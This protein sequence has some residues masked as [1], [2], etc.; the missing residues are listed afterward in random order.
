M[1]HRRI[2]IDLPTEIYEQC[3]L[4]AEIDGLTLSELVR[5]LLVE[6]F[7]VQRKAGGI[8]PDGFQ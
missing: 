8:C 3:R 7:D 1:E 5:R 2:E 6:H 4:L